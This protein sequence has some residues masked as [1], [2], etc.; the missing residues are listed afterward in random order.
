MNLTLKFSDLYD[1]EQ[2]SDGQ[3]IDLR[4]IPETNS[5]C[6]PQARSEILSRILPYPLTGIHWID[7][8]D[9][10]Y[11]SEIFIG[12]AQEPFCLA[13]LDN[14]SD[15]QDGAFGGGM[16]SCGNWVK[17]ARENNPMLIESI[18][19]TPHLTSSPQIP[20]YIS[21]DLDVL[22][23][24]FA[25]TNWNQGKMSLAELEEMITRIAAGRR[26]LGIDVC[27]GLTVAKGA[28]PADICINLQTRRALASF[29]D[30]GSLL[31]RH[32]R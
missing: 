21:I 10:H 12:R 26:V 7:S 18:W 20:V 29:L 17:V 1:D 22:S 6:S 4:D 14:H 32:L 13:L 24:E 16:L 9:Y 30:R 15:A 5:Y 27:G 31:S 28:G 19:N 2:F 8:G 11:A 25:R 3:S 23:P